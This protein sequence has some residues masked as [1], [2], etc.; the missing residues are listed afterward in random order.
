M[1]LISL[2]NSSVHLLRRGNCIPATNTFKDALEM[3]KS[4]ANLSESNTANVLGLAHRRVVAADARP[5]DHE[6]GV[7]AFLSSHHPKQAYRMLRGLQ[8]S[9][10]CL[11][12]DESDRTLTPTMLRAILIFNYGIAHRCYCLVRPRNAHGLQQFCLQVFLY[13]EAVSNT[14]P[15][16][17]P[18]NT[19]FRLVLTRNL[20]LYSCQL[21]AAQQCQHYKDTLRHVVNEVVGLDSPPRARAYATPQLG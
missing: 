21:G 20:M 17:T 7:V 13:S 3:L 19:L 5:V 18:T 14:T 2:N 15:R 12:M 16:S 9:T 4:T 10:A 1:T 11:I 8:I 6:N